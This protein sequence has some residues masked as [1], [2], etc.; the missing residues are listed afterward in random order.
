MAKKMVTVEYEGKSLP[1]PID[2][3]RAGTDAIKAVFAASGFPMVENAEISIDWP[4]GEGAAPNVHIS[5]KSTGKGSGQLLATQSD[6][7]PYD[8]F[9]KTLLASPEYINPAT[10]LA[11][12][13]IQAEAQGD[14][15]FLERAAQAGLV[16][17]AVMEGLRESDALE[18]TLVSCGSAQPKASQDVPVGF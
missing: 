1:V 15:E 12:Q 14:T 8:E 18:R 6:G 17:R 9:I 16:E 10:A 13:A 5:P 2:V 7:E 11:A 3:V 4:Q